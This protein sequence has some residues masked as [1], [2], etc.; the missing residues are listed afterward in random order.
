MVAGDRVVVDGEDIGFLQDLTKPICPIILT[1]WCK[2]RGF[3]AA[4]AIFHWGSR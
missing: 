4:S 1:S 3:P 2:G